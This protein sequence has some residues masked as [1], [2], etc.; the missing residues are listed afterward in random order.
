MHRKGE[1]ERKKEKKN[2]VELKQS[3]EGKACVLE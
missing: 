2:T 3:E 1:K